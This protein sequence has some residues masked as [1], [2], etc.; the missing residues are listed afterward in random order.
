MTEEGLAEINC[1]D[2]LKQ[3]IDAMSFS[4]SCVQENLYELGPQGERLLIVFDS[5]LEDMQ[6]QLEDLLE[7]L[8]DD[9]A[10]QSE[11]KK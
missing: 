1:K 9:E 6:T 11:D 3:L 10:A 2:S 7:D 5:R 4:R 8:L